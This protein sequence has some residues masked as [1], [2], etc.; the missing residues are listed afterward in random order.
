MHGARVQGDHR[1][2]VAE[3]WETKDGIDRSDVGAESER[4]CDMIAVPDST[5]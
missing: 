1:V 2:E 4:K 5:G 3:H